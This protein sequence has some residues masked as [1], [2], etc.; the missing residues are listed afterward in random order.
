MCVFVFFVMLPHVLFSFN[1]QHQNLHIE[2]LINQPPN[3]F[4][5]MKFKPWI[6]R[7]NNWNFLFFLH[8]QTPENCSGEGDCMPMIIS[9]EGAAEIQSGD[10]LIVEID[11]SLLLPTDI[12]LRNA[13]NIDNGWVIFLILIYWLSMHQYWPNHRYSK[14]V[15]LTER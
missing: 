11:D 14:L 1:D 6:T 7:R 10:V 8:F 4:F 9:W 12:N 3:W 2:N 15:F 13:N 5:P